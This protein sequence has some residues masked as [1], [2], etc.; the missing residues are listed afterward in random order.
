MKIEHI[1]H[2]V[3]PGLLVHRQWRRRRTEVDYPDYAEAVA[4]ARAMAPWLL[5]RAAAT[6]AAGQILPET[7]DRFHEAGLWRMVQPRRVGGLE[8]P[9]TAFFDICSEIARGC[10]SSAWVLGNIAS[11]HLMLAHW[12]ER[13]QDEVWGESPDVLI[14]ATL[15]FPAGRAVRVPGGY[16]LTGTFPFSSGIDP[17]AWVMIG[18]MAEVEGKADERRY[19][20]LPRCDYEILDTWQVAGL[21]GTGSKDVR[22][23]DVFVPDYRTVS[24][25]ALI[26]CTGPGLALNPAA[27]FRY[28]FWAAGGYV[29]LST[30]YGTAAGALDRFT[31]T[32]RAS[33]AVSSGKGIA[34][35]ATL[36]Q[37]IGRA[38]ALIDTIEVV[39]R[40]RLTDMH[41]LLERD[42]VIDA[43]SAGKIR[44]DVSYLASLA[45]EAIDLLFTA[46]GGSAL[47]LSNPLQRAWRDIHAGVGN[48]T[49]QWDAVGP[50]YGRILLGLPSGL[51]GMPV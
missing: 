34:Q 5:E 42:G 25:D 18:S 37:R 51:P 41:A 26:G 13:A 33:A 11:H 8:L 12:P 48:F 40:Q 17:C 35:H 47:Y 45:A 6:E 38:A 44:R 4:R 31:A 50:A 16:R 36:Q 49:L 39:A 20:L 23:T 30:L 27:V 7:T 3:E 10:A 43:V 46:A 21:Q 29:L 28:P 9:S 24:Y 19:F 22:I 15:V 32:V 2:A 1:P 14:G